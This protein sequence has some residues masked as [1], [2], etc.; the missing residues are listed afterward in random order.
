MML[1]RLLI[2]RRRS[3]INEWTG[4]KKKETEENK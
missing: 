3:K 1:N 2:L 4:A